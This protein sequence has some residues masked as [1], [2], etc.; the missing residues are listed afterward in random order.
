MLNLFRILKKKNKKN[1]NFK[2]T[3]NQRNKIIELAK[4]QIKEEKIHR[5]MIYILDKFPEIVEYIFILNKRIE[6][7]E[8]ID[9]FCVYV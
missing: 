5:E 8:N 7:L 4:M 9:S 1:N 2:L 6:K 3:I